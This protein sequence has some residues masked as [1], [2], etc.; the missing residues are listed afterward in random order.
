MLG[1]K[2]L[3]NAEYI[4]LRSL[5]IVLISLPQDVTRLIVAFKLTVI[6]NPSTEDDLYYMPKLLQ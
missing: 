2:M 1:C 4:A 3:Q 5:Q 6:N